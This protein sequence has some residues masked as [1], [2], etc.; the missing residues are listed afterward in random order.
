M[1]T[2][3]AVMFGVPAGVSWVTSF[4]VN[5]RLSLEL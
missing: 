5:A 2:S 3:A 1:L 4:G